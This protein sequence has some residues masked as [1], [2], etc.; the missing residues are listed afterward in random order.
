MIWAVQTQFGVAKG[1][2]DE[3]AMVWMRRV[4]V[5]EGPEEAAGHAHASDRNATL[6]LERADHRDQSAQEGGLLGGRKLVDGL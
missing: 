3:G 1:G 4:I 6:L 2:V 5:N